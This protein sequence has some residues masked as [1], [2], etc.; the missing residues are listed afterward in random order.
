MSDK[1]QAKSGGWLAPVVLTVIHGILWFA[2]LGL[3]LRLVPA[4]EKIFAD[5]GTEL[6]VATI[7]AI[8]LSNLAFR[9]WYLAILV[10]AG[11]CAVDLALLRALFARPKL[12]V[13]AWLWAMWMFLM[14]LVLMVWIV[15]SLWIP[16]FHVMHDLS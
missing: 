9:F 15:I 11:L 2:W 14:P 7:W 5:F 10:V 6:P 16:F 3:L 4:Y 13:L 1:K 12:A 8:G